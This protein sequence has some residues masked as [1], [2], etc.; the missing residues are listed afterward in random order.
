VFGEWY[1]FAFEQAG[2][3]ATGCSPD[4]PA[5]PFCLPS[6]GT[7]TLFADAPPWTF[8]APAGATLTVTDAFESGDQFEILDFGVVIGMTSLPGALVDCGDDPVPCLAS[9][10]ISSGI[11]ALAAGAHS[12]VIV[13]LQAPSPGSGYF[14]VDADAAV[15]P[16]PST[17]LLLGAGVGALAWRRKKAV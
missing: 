17:L 10:E 3:T 5:G 6:S 7:P 1:E 13:P 12:L 16:E 9:S 8:N 15:V 2:V 4:D 11:F 14:R